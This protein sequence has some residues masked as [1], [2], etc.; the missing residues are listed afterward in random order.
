[1]LRSSSCFVIFFLGSNQFMCSRRR[2]QPLCCYS[3]VSLLWAS[4]YHAMFTNAHNTVTGAQKAIPGCVKHDLP[5]QSLHLAYHCILFKS[6]V[7]LDTHKSAPRVVIHYILCSYL[8]NTLL[9]HKYSSVNA[10]TFTQSG[11]S[12][13]LLDVRVCSSR[14]PSLYMKTLGCHFAVELLR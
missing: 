9:Y 1:M 11:V 10:L 6:S 2:V 13:L 7:F 14:T 5:D 3:R 4:N 8:S 12:L